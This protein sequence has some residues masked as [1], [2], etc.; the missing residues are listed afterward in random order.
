MILYYFIS[1][2]IIFKYL[3]YIR[4]NSNI[5]VS[6]KRNEEKDKE[7]FKLMDK[8]SDLLKTWSE[9][10]KYPERNTYKI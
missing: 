1:Y 5:F 4:E 6:K 8:I 7:E 10:E 2:Y 3:I 9:G